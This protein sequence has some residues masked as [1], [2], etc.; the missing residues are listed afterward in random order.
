MT[1]LAITPVFVWMALRGGIARMISMS[2]VP[3]HVRTIQLVLTMSTPMYAN[4]LQDTVGF[5]VKLTIMT[6]Q[7]GKPYTEHACNI[8]WKKSFLVNKLYKLKSYSSFEQN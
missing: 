2:A 8:F 7:E 1:A 3:T 4:V 5:I 6:A